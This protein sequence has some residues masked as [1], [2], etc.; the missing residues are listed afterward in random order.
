MTGEELAQLP[1]GSIV[2]IDDEEGE[3]LVSGKECHIGWP[4]SS[5]TNIINTE[6]LAWQDFIAYLEA[7]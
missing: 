2:R 7:E 3:I 6:S 1:V 5:C 4:D